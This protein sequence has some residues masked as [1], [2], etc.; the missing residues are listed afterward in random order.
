M[1]TNLEKNIK[2][3]ISDFDGIK[4]AIEEK[5]IAV[6]HGT[7]TKEYKGLIQKIGADQYDRGYEAGYEKG[8]TDG[9][10][11]GHAE[12]VKDGV[13]QGYD[14]GLD[15]IVNQTVVSYSND[16][17]TA[18]PVAFFQGNK[19]LVSISLPKITHLNGFIGCTA[20]KYCDFSG[21]RYIQSGIFKG[22]TSLEKLDF[23]SAEQIHS[24]T[25]ENCTSLTTIILR[26]KDSPVSLGN[27]SS[28]KGTP[29]ENGTGFVYVPAALLE[30]Y[31]TATNWS[32]YAAQFRAIE[33][34]PEITGD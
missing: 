15:A 19:N 33:D 34:Y 17:I 9:Y 13:K 6:P 16:T 21:A 23:P 30:R 22:C 25:F 26:R 32:T 14:E 3:A 10:T 11:K 7:D 24:N 31:K 18:M 20:L 1:M 4:A 28:F 29:M 8:N 12:G 5:G 27:V 2:Q